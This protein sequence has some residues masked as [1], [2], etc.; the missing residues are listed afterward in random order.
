M[1]T[2]DFYSKFYPKILS[3]SPV[4]NGAVIFSS[5]SVAVVVGAVF[6]ALFIFDVLRKKADS[7][8]GA[9]SKQKV[10]PTAMS[11]DVQSFTTSTD[12]CAAS[13][14][15]VA[16][17]DEA[18]SRDWVFRFYR[19]FMTK[20]SLLSILSTPDLFSGKLHMT[21]KWILVFIHIL[22]LLT[23]SSILSSFFYADDGFCNQWESRHDCATFGTVIF[24]GSKVC[25]W[26]WNSKYCYFDESQISIADIITVSVILMAICHP[27]RE[28]L[29]IFAELFL[30]LLQRFNLYELVMKI[31]RRLI[32]PQKRRKK[33]MPQNDEMDSEDEDE[34][35][36]P[37]LFEVQ[38][39]S[40]EL[41]S[42]S[43][44][45]KKSGNLLSYQ[46]LSS[47]LML[48][49]RLVKMQL[50]MELAVLEDELEYLQVIGG[51]L[52]WPAEEVIL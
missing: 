16:V 12:D 27:V 30:Q 45:L 38:K 4:F 19:D 46:T 13:V 9:G 25:N 41:T 5:V 35:Q 40:D 37:T 47:K 20:H 21:S 39:P 51:P 31:K 29:R 11:S 14:F 36:S 50:S 26:N 6:L 52:F 15:R 18:C 22:V 43:S 1:T 48:A 2:K 42:V 32:A 49:A 7:S 44:V 24:V 28:I 10:V 17:P 3:P 33:Y 8:L 23:A 34:F